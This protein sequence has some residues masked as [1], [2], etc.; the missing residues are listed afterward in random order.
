MGLCAVS[1]RGAGAEEELLFLH[2]AYLQN[3]G[4]VKKR[5][6]MPKKGRKKKGE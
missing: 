3:Q 6:K 2:S 1:L 5:K 4:P